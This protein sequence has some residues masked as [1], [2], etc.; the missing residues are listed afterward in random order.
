MR[1]PCRQEES[2][3]LATHLVSPLTWAT[4]Q[5]VFFVVYALIAVPFVTNFVLNTVSSVSIPLHF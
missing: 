3:L 2:V 1:H 4:A 5:R